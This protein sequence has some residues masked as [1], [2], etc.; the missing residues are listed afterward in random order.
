MAGCLRERGRERAPW[1]L[2]AGRLREAEKG[3]SLVAG[4][5][6]LERGGGKALWWPVAAC[7]REAEEGGWEELVAT[8]SGWHSWRL[9][10]GAPR[11][12]G[13]QNL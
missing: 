6:M 10:L 9:E 8:G 3:G 11:R 7:F 4:S 1:W 13:V 2:A 12:R 5:N